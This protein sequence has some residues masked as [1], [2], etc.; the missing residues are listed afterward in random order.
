MPFNVHSFKVVRNISHT[1]EH[2]KTEEK[3]SH[4]F[5]VVMILKV[6]EEW[7]LCALSRQVHDEDHPLFLQKLVIPMVYLTMPAQSPYYRPCKFHCHAFKINIFSKS[8]WFM[9]LFSPLLVY[10]PLVC[11]YPEIAF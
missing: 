6:D 8:R 4:R 10:L 7:V 9:I 5:K 1:F 11:R 3:R 2:K